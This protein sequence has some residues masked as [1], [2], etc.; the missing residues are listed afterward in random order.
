M[1]SKICL[2]ISGASPSD[3]SSSK[4]S[5]GRL[6]SARAIASI[7]CSPA[8]K[9][10]AALVCALLEPGKQVEHA[11]QVVVEMLV[12][13]Q[14]RAPSGDF[15]SPSCGRRSAGL[16]GDWAMPIR[17]I[18]CVGVREMSWP[19][20][21][22]SPVRARGLPQ[23]VIIKVDL[24]APLAPISVTIS[25]LFTSTSTPRQRDDLAVVG[26]DAADCQKVLLSA[27]D[28]PPSP[29]SAGLVLP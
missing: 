27:H 16:P 1:I 13:N 3:G 15:P 12:V 5:F 24:P 23:I 2:T 18:S 29:L 7:C 19:S 6:I 11:F 21:M 4:S 26:L 8:R 9:R 22:I 14:L 20:K 10:A 17:M 25:P 28:W